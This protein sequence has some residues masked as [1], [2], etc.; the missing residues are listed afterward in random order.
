MKGL[1]YK[2]WLVGKKTFL[3][4][5]GMAVLFSVMGILFYL[6]M[7]YGNLQDM[8]KED[9]WGV[10]MFAKMF[11]YLPYM[12]LLFG[13]SVC[14]KTI[15]TD[16]ASGFM[17]YSY[18]LPVS[19]AKAVGAR[20]LM[21]GIVFVGSFLFGMLISGIMCGLSGNAF[22]AEIMKNLFFILLVGIII[23]AAFMPLSLQLKNARTVGTISA[24]LLLVLYAC[25]GIF[26][27]CYGD[28]YGDNFDKFV[29]DKYQMFRDNVLTISPV[30]LLVVVVISL[31]LSMGIYQRR[32]R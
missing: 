24:V 10:S 31:K 25:A 32:E 21:I 19:A 9:P 15:Y 12:L 22:D 16:Y 11:C 2:E 6:S 1:L 20:Y 13:A 26:L 28:R 27:V 4:F 18:T 17:K 14:M 7:F 3:L 29:L 30:L 5:L 8:P 23:V